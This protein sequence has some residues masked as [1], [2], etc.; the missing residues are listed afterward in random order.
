MLNPDATLGVADPALQQLLSDQWEDLLRR[1]PQL[2]SRLGDHRYDHLLGDGSP[3]GVLAAR[4]ARRGFLARAAAL[5]GVTM[6]AADALTLRIFEGDLR[7]EVATDACLAEQ[8]MLSARMNALVDVDW[9]PEGQPVGTV[10][11]G[12]RLLARLTAAPTVV[13]AE[14]DNLRLGM[15]A[16]R[17]PVRASAERVLAMVDERLAQPDA[18]WPFMALLAAP[19]PDWSAMELAAFAAGVRDANSGLRLG[20]QA[21]RGF[22]HDELLPA[23]RG[24][25]RAGVSFLPEGST[26]Y[27]ALVARETS[28]PLDPAV[29]HQ[30]GLSELARIHAEMRVLAARALGTDELPAILSR[31]RSDPALYFST[32]EEVVEAADQALRA[33]EAA[34]PQYFSRLPAA[35]CVVRPIPDSEAPYSTIA[36]YRQAVPGERPGEYRINT[37]APQTRPRFEARVLAFHES[38]PGH[39][40]QI[41]LAQEQPALPAFRR[42]LGSTAYVE[43]WALYTERLADEMGLYRDDLDRLGMLSFDTWRAARLVVDTGIHSQGWTRAQAVA[44]MLA[45]TALTPGNIDNEVDRYIT[46]PG[47]ALA[48]KTGQ[49][50]LWALRRQAEAQLGPAFSLPAF[51]DVVLSLGAVPLPVLREE[52]EAWAS[53]VSESGRP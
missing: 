6:S 44:F 13:Q 24:E 34:V 3:A 40:F 2:A 9:L 1:S 33:A 16:G 39:H 46:W 29:V 17:T 11:E 50:E 36:Y 31:L 41:A 18:D 51:H 7:L 15:A 30:T 12:Q 20:L 27:T 37:Y 53:P 4:Q 10:E 45:N 32:A 28:L 23:A 21:Y 26:C 25:D 38:V 22:L 52:V 5:D 47:Q 48:Y 42:H 35:Q 49:I 14:I 43:G 19:H 8:W